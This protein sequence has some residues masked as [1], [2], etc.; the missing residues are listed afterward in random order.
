[1][2]GMIASIMIGAGLTALL[3]VSRQT[4]TRKLRP[5][6]TLAAAGALIALEVA[7]LQS[8]A[9]R[10]NES[11]SLARNVMGQLA[12]LRNEPFVHVRNLPHILADG[13]YVLK[14][15][16]L[17]MYLERTEGRSP[18]FRCDHV[19]VEFN[20]EGYEEI[21]PREPDEFS[22]YREPQPGEH[23]VELVFISQRNCPSGEIRTCAARARP[24]P[25][26]VRIL[27]LGCPDP[28]DVLL[29]SSR[30]EA[31][32]L[33]RTGAWSAGGCLQGARAFTVHGGQS[34]SSRV[35]LFR[36]FND[37][38]HSASLDPSC[39]DADTEGAVGYVDRLPAASSSLLLRGC[40][41]TGRWRPAL[42]IG[43]PAGWTATTLGYVS[44]APSSD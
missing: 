34:S 29:T 18:Q 10:F 28:T 13:P 35:P 1:M 38:F 6:V 11:A 15:Y 7:S 24:M 3:D 39:G 21:T 5:A 33:L 17:A 2:S 44:P 43:C 19:S 42:G 4:G 26:R 37:R 14:C 22:N 32:A 9:R 8:F 30:A 27:S 25:H 12:P 23:D 36:C 20:G 31:G 40:S 41:Q 16:A